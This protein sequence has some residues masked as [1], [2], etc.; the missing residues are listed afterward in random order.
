MVRRDRE[1]QIIACGSKGG[2]ERNR[3][4]SKREKRRERMSDHCV[5]GSHC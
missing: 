2:D 3:R 5:T 4:E 1:H